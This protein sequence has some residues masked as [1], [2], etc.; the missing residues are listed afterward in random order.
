MKR[1]RLQAG[2][3]TVGWICALP[4]ELATAE[5]MLDEED[6]SLAQDSSDDNL[7]TLGR[8]GGH[9]VVLAYLPAG[10]TGTQ[11][12]AT[13]AARMRSKFA[14]IR[15]GLMVGI[16]GGVP[17]PESDIRLGD[18]VIS[19]PYLQHRGV[20]QYDFG[21]TGAGGHIAR[22]GS[23]NAPPVVLLNAVSK[24]RA[25]HYRGRSNL[26]TY[27]STFDP[28]EHFSRSM[29]G[30]D[31]LF[32]AT[33]NHIG[34]ATCEQCSREKEV[35]RTPRVGQGVA[36]HY[37]TIAS[38]N[39]VIKDAIT[40]D[41]ISKELGGVMCFEMEAAGL[42]NNLPC[43]VI[44]GICD[45]ADSHKNKK[46]QPYAAATAAACAKE[47]LSV[48]PAT[49]VVTTRTVDEATIYGILWSTIN[50]L[51]LDQFL[52]M[53]L[54]VGQD[55]HIS[56]I[57]PLDRNHPSFYWIFR[58]LDFVQWSSA[59]CSQVLWLSGPPERNIH[60]VSSYIVGQGKKTDH[61]VLYF[62]C[63]AAI[64]R[65]SIVTAFVHTL[66]KQIVCCSPMNKR[67]LIIRSFL[68]SLLKEA[69]QKEAIP[70]WKERDFNEKDTPATNIHEILNAP[71]NTLLSA[72]G[73]FLVY[74]EQR[75]LLIVVDGL[76]QV[77]HQPDELG[78]IRVFVERLQQRTSKV[79]ILLTSQPLAKI[80]DQFNGLPWIEHD[81]ERKECLASLRFDNTRYKK[82][83]PEYKGSFEW[84]WAHNEYKKWSTPDASQL[85]YIQGKPGS[86]KSTLAKY[87]NQNLLKREPAV[88]LATIARFFYSFREGEL[89]R[90]HYN[91]FRS[92]LYDILK[93]DETFFYHRFQTEYRGQ[94]RHGV[95]FNWDYASLKTVLKSIQDYSA[96]KR[97]YLIIDA[98][99]ESEDN[100]R[101][102]VLDL[103]FKLCARTKH[104]IVKV[105][106]ASRP[107]GQLEVRRS[108][109]HNF[110]RLQDETKLDISSFASSFLNRL[111]LRRH[112]AQAT[113]YIVKNAQGVFLW[114]KLVGKELL[115]CEEQGHSEK[116][117]LEFLKQLPTELR[118]FYTLMLERMTRNKSN[119]PNKDMRNI[120]DG[121]KMFRFVLF[122]R[123]PLTVDELRHALI[124][125]DN[126]DTT[127]TPSDNSVQEDIL[128]SKQR[129]IYCGGNFL[130]IKYNHGSGT[131]Q[132]MHQT[133]REFFLDPCGDV[134]NS[135]FRMCKKDA[136]ICISIICIRYLMLCAAN[137]TLAGTLPHVELWTSE[138][139][140]YYAQY[141][142]KR[143]LANYALSYLTHHIDGCH[144]D[145]NVLDITSRFVDEVTHNPAVY[146]LENWV[147]SCLDQVIL[148]KEQGAAAKEFR[149]KVL[150]AA[151][152][153]GLS[154]SAEVLLTVGAD[155]NARD[156]FG[157]TPLSRAAGGGHEAV[158]KLL[159]ETGKAN[160]DSKD[161]DSGRTP[162]SRA[163]EGGHEAVVGLLLETGKVDV[164]SGDNNGQTPLSR[165]AE[166]GHEAVVKLLL[167]TGKVDV[168]PSGRTPLSRAA[169]GG[170]EAVVKLLFET[171]KG[172]RRFEG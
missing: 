100:D 44:R 28:L 31:I 138:R 156:Q 41:R 151:V 90:S 48:I 65:K 49:E 141:L 47:I 121:V 160:V 73:A 134:A 64:K 75:S 52:K 80:K 84:I 87:F 15:F 67:I 6:E 128:P 146:L 4:I 19:Q 118:E 34:G 16:G 102:D 74:E 101:R 21:K 127:F 56:T 97:L 109:F 69:F 167:E 107:V 86:G 46:W 149:N 103:L 60:Q 136:H 39:Q 63:S 88:N 130:E 79:K 157:W 137:T 24:L 9:N 54:E 42:M 123:R 117:I 27:L 57:P 13:V 147:S 92:I 135:K 154:T 96:A 113:Q 33:Y 115:E 153:N 150:H 148:G 30:P 98:V 8:I 85:L 5:E 70:N 36:I 11:S 68:H 139:F 132:V 104:C 106:V 2:D 29:V 95:P 20:V 164:D 32:E 162:L 12:A 51:N 37:G 168:D 152:R 172:R 171:G 58:N 3:Y 91:M 40:R 125:P 165:A 26:A 82:I 158:V 59:G 50:K 43:L 22:T 83:S 126:L 129:I 10:Q 155:V 105:F 7:Y 122:A 23:L 93:H 161:N 116:D 38:G 17:T 120:W 114:V 112:L 108:Q 124:I 140:E 25:L 119:L 145:A 1:R 159:L 18:V 142:D 111:S 81:R 76:G 62:F 89:Q 78:E 110:I 169:E 143:P 66:L 133:V 55:E 166:G 131:V 170:H 99:D 94:R 35:K 163:A 14:S 71:A 77:E 61:L 45:Y 144:R 72:L 53:L